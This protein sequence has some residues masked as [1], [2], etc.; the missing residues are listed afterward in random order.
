L[1]DAEQHEQFTDRDEASASELTLEKALKLFSDAKKYVDTGHRT[2]W[3]NYFKVY[4]GKRVI[5]NY[6]GISDPVIREAHTIIETLVSN[7]AS[8]YPKFSFVQTNEEQAKDTEILND[9]L[10]YYMECNQ[11]GLKNQEWVRDMLLYGTGVLGVEWRDGEPFIFNIPLRDFFFD[12]TSTGLVQTL[13]PAEYAGYEYLANKESLKRE[14]IFDAEKNAWVPRYTGLD[15]LGPADKKGGASGAKGMDKDFKDM[16]RG[17]T[18]GE[19]A[20]EDQIHVIK[21]HHLPTGR[22]YEIG[23]KKAF[24]YNKP[25]WCQREEMTRN[26]IT[27][28]DDEEV[29][30]EQ[31]LDE[32]ILAVCSSARLCRLQPIPRHR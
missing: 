14:K 3:D 15:D 11:M 25:T 32:I 13:N 9:M 27:T 17:S 21:L 12:P 20:T 6:E 4:D 10:E 7:I 2:N 28:V 31:K 1:K 29:P 5:R 30:Y 18:L 24:I 19:T 23:N 22:I 26:V 16:F 8:G